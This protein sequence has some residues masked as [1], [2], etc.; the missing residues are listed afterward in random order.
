MMTVTVKK[1]TLPLT[2]TQTPHDHQNQLLL[3]GLAL[4]LATRP[5]HDHITTRPAIIIRLPPTPTRT[6]HDHKSLLLL[7]N[8]ALP[9]A[10][11]PRHDNVTTQPRH[12]NVTTQP[13]HDP[14]QPP[15][16]TTRWRTKGPPPRS[17]LMIVV[18][19][20]RSCLLWEWL[21]STR[22]TK[23]PPPSP[24]ASMSSADYVMR[25]TLGSGLP[26]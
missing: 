6:L 13:L 19:R 12:D 20:Q 24:T 18:S 1:S 3:L 5:T 14:T 9:L 17:P 25:Q 2:P 15:L 23:G 16:P 7:L 4:L 8:L 10:T 11:R 26:P 22:R 21:T